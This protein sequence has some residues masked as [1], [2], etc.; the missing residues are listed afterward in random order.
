MITICTLEEMYPAMK[1]ATDD[2]VPILRDGIKMISESA[3]TMPLMELEYALNDSAL[4]VVRKYAGV[5]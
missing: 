5:S 1:N 3:M 4:E 2:E